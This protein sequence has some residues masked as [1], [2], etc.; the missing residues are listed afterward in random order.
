MG[1]DKGGDSSSVDFIERRRAAL[2][3][4]M[5]RTAAHVTL[6]ADPDFREFVELGNVQIIRKHLKGGENS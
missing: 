6:R 4:Y 3:R 2:E 5:I 1:N